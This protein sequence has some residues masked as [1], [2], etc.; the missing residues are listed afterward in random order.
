MFW[1]EWVGPE[2]GRFGVNGRMFIGSSSSVPDA[3]CAGGGCGAG[4]GW[5]YCWRFLAKLGVELL[6]G[7]QN[8][9]AKL[10]SSKGGNGLVELE[11]KP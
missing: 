7:V 1:E 2:K 3:G 5:R 9:F 6:C 8:S 10:E 4:G 11:I